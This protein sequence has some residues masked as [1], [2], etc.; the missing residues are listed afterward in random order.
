[1]VASSGSWIVFLEKKDGIHLFRNAILQLLR[2]GAR[3]VY[4][5]AA[6]HGIAAQ[7]CNYSDLTGNGFLSH[8]L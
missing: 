5:K 6:I 3:K 2:N 7:T 8:S 4:I 1:M